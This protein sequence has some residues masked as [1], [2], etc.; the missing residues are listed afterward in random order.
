MPALFGFGIGGFAS[1]LAQGIKEGMSIQEYKQQQKLNDLKLKQLEQAEKD[2]A[3]A[4][5]QVEQ[6]LGAADAASGSP[7]SQQPTIDE[8]LLSPAPI[9]TP[10]TPSRAGGPQPQSGNQMAPALTSSVRKSGAA[11]SN[12]SGIPNYAHHLATQ[13]AV[14]DKPDEARDVLAWGDSAHAQDVIKKMGAVASASLVAKANGNIAPLNT[15]VRSL[16]QSMDPNVTQGLKFQTINRVK[17]GY[18]MT[19][20]GPNG[21][22]VTDK[23]ASVNDLVDYVQH[24]AHPHEYFTRQAATP[25]GKAAIAQL[26]SGNQAPPQQGQPQPGAPQR[27]PAPS[28]PQAPPQGGGSQTPQQGPQGQT[29]A[30]AAYG[31]PPSGPQ[32]AYMPGQQPSAPQAQPVAPQSQQPPAPV[33]QPA[34]TAQQ[35]AP[36]PQSGGP[37]A[38]APAPVPAMPQQPAAAQRGPITRAIAAAQPQPSA[39]T[40]EGT[41]VRNMATVPGNP[42]VVLQGRAP[43]QGPQPAMTPQTRAQLAAA[44]TSSNEQVRAIGAEV[45]SRYLP[46][47]KWQIE[48]TNDGS[49]LAINPANPAQ[50]ML[51][52]QGGGEWK[53]AR[54]GTDNAQQPIYGF[55]NA[56]T[57]Q[58]IPRNVGTGAGGDAGASALKNLG[59]SP[60]E[61]N[62][63]ALYYMR[64]GKFPNLGF[65]QQANA[66]KLAITA[67]A[68]DMAANDVQTSRKAQGLEPL[69][70]GPD[71]NAAAARHMGDMQAVYAGAVSGARSVGT[72]GANIRLAGNLATTAIPAALQ[73]SD[74]ISRTRWTPV[75][76]ALLMAYRSGSNVALS[77]WD[78]ANLQIAEMYARA[79]NPLG[80]TIREDMFNRAVSVLS[81]AKSPEAYRETLKTI[82]ANIT[83]EEGAIGATTAQEQGQQP[84]L[85]N[86]F[87]AATGHSEDPLGLGIAAQNGSAPNSDPLG[88]FQ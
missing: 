4:P 22:R 16:W 35:P 1:G 20:G 41:P 82:Y 71:L 26:R 15:S 8:G 60:D 34:A 68:A 2:R 37:L 39:S 79:L 48:K 6:L 80:N 67:R 87:E 57:G 86:P 69:P 66:A 44:L 23:F 27:T 85:P 12:S 9:G 55:V 65:G 18:V 30:G 42:G 19:F 61:A 13:L 31:F 64:T 63:L 49:I 51:V 73:A 11:P 32:P 5:K 78:V 10:D 47:S 52:H 62:T 54:I 46:P 84:N 88:L 25:A 76:A 59:I 21:K 45:L 38:A 14:A 77:R 29:P 28:Q 75:N 7:T 56:S 24:Y 50:Q 58:I 3:N 33:Q 17:D 83:R 40:F 72:R 53:F 36:Q 74:A 81:Q 43:A 70:K